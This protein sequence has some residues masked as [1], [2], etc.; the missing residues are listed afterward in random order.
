M[1]TLQDLQEQHSGLVDT[2]AN[3]RAVYDSMSIHRA[4]GP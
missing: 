3:V 1:V 2:N 4:H